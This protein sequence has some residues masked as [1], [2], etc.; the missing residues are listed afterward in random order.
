MTNSEK[1]REFSS[2]VAKSQN[3]ELPNYAIPFS[4]YTTKFLIK[5]VIDE[6]I[7]LLAYS[8]VK[9]SERKKII[10]TIVEN[11]DYRPD[12][13]FLTPSVEG[14]MDSL[15]DIEYYM[16]DVA[17][18]HGQNIDKVF[19]L[20]HE[21]NMNKRNEQGLFNLRD[22]G[23]V[24]KPKDWKPAD[25]SSEVKRQMRGNSFEDNSLR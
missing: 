5:M 10:S 12:L 15:V 21:A 14:Q 17:A 22:D 25:I 1:V 6:L 18:R 4:R 16:K 11:E 23:K 20:V 2:L 7:E 13:G 19:D 8:G 9:F 24:L 3:K